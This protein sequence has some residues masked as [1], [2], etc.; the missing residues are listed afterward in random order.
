MAALTQVP[1][2]DRRTLPSSPSV[3]ADACPATSTK[4]DA[5]PVLG[6]P[7]GDL[8]LLKEKLLMM[9]SYAETAVNRAVK[10]LARRDDDLA[11]R[12]SEED[13]RIDR[14]ELEVDELA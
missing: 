12:T 3:S 8:A 13:D 5:V 14:L 1:P 2:A 10:A 4:V 6:E 9:A 11:S 7:S